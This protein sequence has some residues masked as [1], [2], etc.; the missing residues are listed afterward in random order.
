MKRI[1]FLPFLI[2]C[3]SELQAQNNWPEPKFNFLVIMGGS[4]FSFEEVNGLDVETQVIE[5]RGG[6]S[7]TFSATKMPSIK[8]YGNVTLKKGITNDDFTALL[9]KAKAN[10]NNR[11]TIIIK[12][13]DENREPTMTCTLKNAFITKSVLSKDKSVIESIEVAHEGLSISDGK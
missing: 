11:E 2:I 10:T 7:K 13:M 4:E 3:T 1:F 6:N 8:K 5:Y 12:L 9:A